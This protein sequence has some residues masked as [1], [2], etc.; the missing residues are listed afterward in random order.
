MT[1]EAV[2][3]VEACAILNGE[4]ERDISVTATSVAGSA[5]GGVDYGFP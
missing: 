2:G 5:I 4:I 1:S 3:S